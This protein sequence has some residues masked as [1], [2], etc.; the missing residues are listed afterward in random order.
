MYITETTKHIMV[1]KIEAYRRKI[2]VKKAMIFQLLFR[3]SLNDPFSLPK[4][5]P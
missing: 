5:T 4:H 2:F 3:H 1:E